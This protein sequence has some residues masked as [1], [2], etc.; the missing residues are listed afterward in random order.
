MIFS[1][2]FHAGAFCPFWSPHGSDKVIK[3]DANG[4]ENE[5]WRKQDSM[6]I[7]E[8]AKVKIM[9]QLN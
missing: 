8:E 3:G 1:G 2:A 6:K 4:E 7:K 9:V 5:S